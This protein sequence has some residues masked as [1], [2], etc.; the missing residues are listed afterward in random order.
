MYSSPAKQKLWR[1]R[2]PKTPTFSPPPRRDH[3]NRFKTPLAASKAKRGV[4][5]SPQTP[6]ISPLPPQSSSSSSPSMTPSCSRHARPGKTRFESAPSA[7]SEVFELSR[8]K[9][10]LGARSEEAEDCFG[11]TRCTLITVH[12]NV[13]GTLNLYSSCLVFQSILPDSSGPLQSPTLSSPPPKPARSSSPAPEMFASPILQTPSTNQHPEHK[14]SLFLTPASNLSTQ[15]LRERDTGPFSHPVSSF[16]AS[17][18]KSPSSPEQ[19]SSQI[20]LTPNRINFT[21]LQ[22]AKRK[23]IDATNDQHHVDLRIFAT[24]C[25]ET[26]KNQIT[27]PIANVEGEQ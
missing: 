14:S 17:P 7:E 22:V 21:P 6:Q 27:V 12:G 2:Q 23:K 15:Y 10:P 9:L 4:L 11:K 8:G 13:R 19:D 3:L 16:L 1:R 18:Q 20:R 5:S 24:Q 26:T 25:T